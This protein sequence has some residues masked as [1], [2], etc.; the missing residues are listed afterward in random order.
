MVKYLLKIFVL[1]AFIF[2]TAQNPAFAT[3]TEPLDIVNETGK[4]ILSLYAVPVQKKDWGNDLVGHGVMSQGDRR[5][6]Y[7][8]IDYHYYKIKAEFAD[9]E[10]ITFKDVDLIDMWR[11]SIW[12]NGTKYEILKNGRG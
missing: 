3:N 6:I 12:L 10:I 8:D 1:T 2:V 4:T 9:G 5:I 11:L 7:Y